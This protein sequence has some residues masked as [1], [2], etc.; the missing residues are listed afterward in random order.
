MRCN[1]KKFNFHYH[2][3]A[4]NNLPNADTHEHKHRRDGVIIFKLGKVTATHNSEKI[5]IFFYRYI[6]RVNCLKKSELQKYG[7]L[8]KYV[9]PRPTLTKALLTC[10]ADLVFQHVKAHK[11]SYQLKLEN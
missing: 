1:G 3:L 9:L 2:S 5:Y 4:C 10:G 6:V 7:N 11:R 8:H